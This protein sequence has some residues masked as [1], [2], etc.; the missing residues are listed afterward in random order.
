M[1]GSEE[2]QRKLQGESIPSRS[3]SDSPPMRAITTPSNRPEA[4]EEGESGRGKRDVNSAPEGG[5]IYKGVSCSI[6]H[7]IL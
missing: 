6:S 5:E 2:G 1:E 7:H 4:E 3:S